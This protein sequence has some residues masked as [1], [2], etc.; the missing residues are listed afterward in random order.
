MLLNFTCATSATNIYKQNMDNSKTKGV[1]ITLRSRKRKNG[2]ALY[3]DIIQD[4]V[5]KMEYLKLYLTGGKTRKEINQDKETMR[6]AEFIRAQRLLELQNERLGL[7]RKE[8]TQKRITLFTYIDE[9][10][11]Q[12]PGKTTS[13]GWRNMKA[14]V[15]A[16]TKGEDIFLDEITKSWVRGFRQFL[17]KSTVFDIDTRKRVDSKKN[18][19]EGTKCLLFQKFTTVF[20]CAVKDEYLI[21]NPAVGIEGFEESYAP[22]EFLTIEELRH[23]ITV[24]PPHKEVCE[25]FIF[26]CL[27]GLRWSDIVNLR[28]ENVQKLEKYTRIVFKQ[29]KTGGIEYLDLTPQAGEIIEKHRDNGEENVFTNLTTIQYARSYVT[30]WVKSA[31]IKKHITFH[32]ARHT[33]ATMLLTLDVNLHTVQKLLGHKSLETTE[34]YARLVDK[35]KQAAVCK[36]PDIL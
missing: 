35:S 11:S 34:I 28:W 10:I 31:G 13:Q 2:E 24:D 7:T 25:A 27:T 8:N 33:F 3:L 6:Q 16:Y 22:R 29:Q 12:R 23:L 21:T 36:I 1:F 32:C 30:A 18:I 15:M 5:R 19:S 9:L 14:R 20:R 4:G 26:S 17:D